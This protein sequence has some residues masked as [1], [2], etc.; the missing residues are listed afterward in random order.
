MS[1]MRWRAADGAPAGP[2]TPVELFFDLVFVFT[3]TQLTQRLEHDLSLAEAGRSLLLFAILWWMY[4]GYA[5]LT[6]HVPPRQTSQKLLLFAGMVGFYVAAL[7]MPHAFD[8]SG[9]VFGVGYLIVIVVHLLL[10]TQGDVRAGVMRLVP[11]NLTSAL[12]ILAAGFTRGTTVYALWIAALAL[13]AAA[14]YLAPRRAVGTAQLFHVAPGHFAERHSLLLIVALGE[15]VVAIGMG[16]RVDHFTLGL[17]CVVALALALPGAMFWTYF[18]DVH[19]G[20]QALRR[21]DARRRS[22]LAVNAYFFPYIPMLLGI[23][24]AAAGMRAV[25][26]N[27]GRRLAPAEAAALAAGVALFLGGV[28]LF[29]GWL[30]IAPID[31]RLIAAAVV[32]ATIPIGAEAGAGYQL[33][34]IVA[35]LVVMLALDRRATGHDAGAGS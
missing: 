22:L 34:A 21:A 16:A 14:P 35:A 6:N 32:L 28:A 20:E 5:W 12:L 8:G 9:V 11:I 24:A 33:A 4:S 23:V 30:R 29:R 2:V 31:G 26:G 3:L 1:P 7:G 25:V 27:L 13:Q 18:T 19:A 15:S 10:F 17:A